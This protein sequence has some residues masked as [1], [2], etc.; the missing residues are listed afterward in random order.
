M[1]HC[2]FCGEKTLLEWRQVS[3]ED[4]DKH[5]YGIQCL[6]CKTI[7]PTSKTRTEAA[8]LW[9]KRASGRGM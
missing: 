8:V 5:E 3:D 6:N 7:G 4:A 9:D 1:K 2:P